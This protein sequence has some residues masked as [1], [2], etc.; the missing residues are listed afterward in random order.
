MATK[1]IQILDKDLR[2]A[3]NVLQARV[4]NCTL[5]PLK[6]EGTGPYTQAIIIDNVLPNDKIDI[7]ADPATLKIIIDNNYCLCVGNDNGVVTAYAVGVKP[8]EVISV[9]L[10]V[11]DVAKVTNDVIW[12][13][14]LR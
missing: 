7:Q 4:V 14:P 1:K 6:W 13:T 12:G 11:T 3:I 10:L 2:A 9:Q 5:N 8:E